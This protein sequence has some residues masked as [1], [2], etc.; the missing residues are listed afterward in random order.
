MVVFVAILQDIKG[1]IYK[2]NRC[3]IQV[4][5]MLYTCYMQVTYMLYTGHTRKQAIC[6]FCCLTHVAVQMTQL[7]I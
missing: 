6:R 5:Y 4:I 3:N 2:L 7:E 1:Y